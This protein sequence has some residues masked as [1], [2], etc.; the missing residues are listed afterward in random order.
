MRYFLILSLLLFPFE[1]FAFDERHLQ[2][3]KSLNQCKECNLR[4]AVLP[5]ADL[6]NADLRNANL[7]NADLRKSKLTDADLTGANMRDANIDDAILC[8]TKMPWGEENGGC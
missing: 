8:R 4:S 2:K 3:L 7:S 6:T 1:S 5:N